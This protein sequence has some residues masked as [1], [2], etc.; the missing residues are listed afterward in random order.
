MMKASFVSFRR[1]IAVG[2]CVMACVSL[3]G[4]NNVSSASESL[5]VTEQNESLV[6]V[7]KGKLT[8]L[9]SATTSVEVASPI[10]VYATVQGAFHSTVELGKYVHAGEE[11][12]TIGSETVT[13]PVDGILE[14]VAADNDVAVNYPLFTV[15]YGGMASQLDASV[16]LRTIDANS[17]ITG[18]FQI[19]DGQGPTDCAAVVR[20]ASDFAGDGDSDAQS[21]EESSQILQ[22][23][24][25]KDVIVRPGQ[26]ATTVL[27]ATAVDEA[28]LLPISSVA[29]RSEKG[30]VSKYED[31]SYHT[32][33]VQ[34]GA[35]D[36][37]SIII[38]SGLR[39]G[40]E[41][42]SIAPNLTAGT[43][44]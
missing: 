21:A 16:L 12:G 1:N 15:R 2:I 30:Q 8:P 41:V 13:A 34:L 14:Y 9:I 32:V 23:L 42:S 37:T 44:S 19:S 26:T 38:V 39:E 5:Q 20:T 3:G 35:S 33:D 43:E 22:C 17:S 36:G 25:P 28:L 29:G 31:G 27:K 7:T 10:A 24:F 40:D 11:L 18:R 6:K 4:C